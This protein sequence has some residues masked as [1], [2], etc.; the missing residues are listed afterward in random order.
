MPTKP[1]VLAIE[2]AYRAAQ[3]RLGIAGAF[4][5]L[6][7]WAGVSPSAPTGSSDAWLTRSLTMINA[8]RRKSSRLARAYYQL[9]RALETGHTLGLPE[10]STDPKQV[11][12]GGLREQFLDLLLDVADLDVPDSKDRNTSIAPTTNADEAWL[13]AELQASAGEKVTAGDRV[14]SM[15]DTDLEPYIRD[16]LDHTDSSTDDTSVPVDEF[17]DWGDGL[18]PTEIRALYE[19]ELKAAADARAAKAARLLQAEDQTAKEAT[20]A[21]QKMH[22]ATGS[23]NAGTVDQAGIDAGREVILHVAERDHRVMMWAR[24]TGRRP[25]AFCSMLAS[26]GFAYKSKARAGA[27]ASSNSYHPNCH[28]TVIMRWADIPDPTAPARTQHYID[29]WRDE[30]KGKKFDALGT[31]ND[32]LNRWRQLIAKERRAE[33]AAQ[34]AAYK[35]EI[36]SRQA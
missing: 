21:L 18:T 25:C 1:E 33:L 12:M 30:I 14:M 13:E 8:L 9:A 29:L 23:V 22:D 10:Y 24:I 16:L 4:L 19:D 32:T 34:R 2:E 28:C 6:K 15:K 5:S 11:T 35:L 27:G 20:K 26:R 7:D 3:A 17:N 36:A 31:T